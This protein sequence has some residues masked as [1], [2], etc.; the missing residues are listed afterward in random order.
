MLAVFNLNFLISTNILDP[1]ELFCSKRIAEKEN[2]FH[3][4]G[5]GINP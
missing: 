2:E 1:D 5:I 3:R 4:R